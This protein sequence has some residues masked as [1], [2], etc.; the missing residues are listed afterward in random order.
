MK[1][2]INVS[3]FL[4]LVSTSIA[5]QNTQIRQRYYL[6]G[7]YSEIIDSPGFQPNK[8]YPNLMNKQSNLDNRNNI[9]GLNTF[10]SGTDE[11]KIQS[12]YLFE[13]SP[14][15][16][17]TGQSYSL[18]F[19]YIFKSGIGL[20]LSLNSAD[21][22][23]KNLALDKTSQSLDIILLGAISGNPNQFNRSDVITYEI[24]TPYR[25]FNDNSF[26]HI[27]FLSFQFA[28]HFFENSRFDPYIRL[29][30]GI[31]KERFNNSNILQSNL[32]FGSRFFLTDD[33]YLLID[34][35]ANNFQSFQ[36]N[37]PYGYL[38]SLYEYSGKIGAGK[39][40]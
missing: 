4:L 13:N 16:K 29:G 23:A 30:F 26:L 9:F 38:W 34:L 17:L 19:E 2:K 12:F 15:P 20:G 40:F 10:A 24:L 11:Q 1:N 3:I 14:K 39:A 7:T 37:P 25:S 21:L 36:N 28:Y 33:Y 35:V 8:I 32:T 5:S 6:E 27:R 18:F 31:G 22:Q